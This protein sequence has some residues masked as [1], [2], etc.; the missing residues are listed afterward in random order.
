M[1]KNC[2]PLP[3]E[4]GS[5]SFKTPMKGDEIDT[6]ISKPLKN[7]NKIEI[8]EKNIEPDLKFKIILVGNMSVGKSCL[9]LRAT[10]GIF[11]ENL[12][13]TVH[14]S[15]CTFNVKINDTKISLQIWDTCGQEKFRALIRSYYTNSS[16]A[17]IVY[18]V[19]DKDSYDDVNMWYKYI[20]EYVSDCK[21]FLIA[22][23]IEIL[24][25]NIEPDLKF[26]IILVGNMS[27]GKSCLT[28]RAT[29]GIFKESLESTVHLSICTFNVKINDTKISLQIWDTCGQEK[30]RALIRSY[31]TNSSLAIIVYSVTDKDSYDDVNIWYKYIKENVSDCKIFLIANKIDSPERII[32]YEQGNKC[33]NDFNF[34]LYMETSAKSGFNA[35]E[36]FINAANILKRE[37]DKMKLYGLNPNKEQ[38]MLSNI[39]LRRKKKNNDED[40]DDEEYDNEGGCCA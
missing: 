32:T 18:S 30:F 29:E 37:H 34:D 28:L 20:K 5:C 21:I 11:K 24:G 40:D 33:R 9:T 39:I 10:E 25:K 26:K 36:L 27:V 7:E 3:S 35:Q 23:K 31:Y 15:I 17:I 38:K 13:S 6:N 4:V 14:L 22:N 2:A 8:L 19:T 16:L 1:E 12:E